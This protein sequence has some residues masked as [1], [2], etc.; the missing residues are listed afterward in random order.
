MLQSRPPNMSAATRSRVRETSTTTVDEIAEFIA[1]VDEEDSIETEVLTARLQ[2]AVTLKRASDPLDGTPQKGENKKKNRPAVIN[3]TDSPAAED[4]D[5]SDE[6]DVDDDPEN[7]PASHAAETDETVEEDDDDDEEDFHEVLSAEPRYELPSAFWKMTTTMMRKK[8]ILWTA[9]TILLMIIPASTTSLERSAP[10]LNKNFKSCMKTNNRHQLVFQQ[11]AHPPPLGPVFECPIDPLLR[12]LLLLR[13][14]IP[15]LVL[16]ELPWQQSLRHQP[17]QP[18]VL[19]CKP[20]LAM[21]PQAPQH[22]PLWTTLP[23]NEFDKNSLSL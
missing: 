4:G 7:T 21:S 5:L 17:P 20:P 3:V 19:T 15:Q 6:D 9:M 2:S 18:H 16:L 22:R 11:T 13:T 12:V 8:M 23:W 1:A 14:T 10:F